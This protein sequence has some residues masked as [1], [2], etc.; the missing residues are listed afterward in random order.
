LNKKVYWI[1]GSLIALAFVLI[2]VKVIY[3][4]QTISPESSRYLWH[5]DVVMHLTGKGSRAKVRLTLP[6]DSERQR[7]YNEHFENDEL[8]FYVRER[9]LTG[10]RIG[11]WKSELLSGSKSVQY[12]FSAQLKSLTYPIPSELKIPEDPLKVYGPELKPWLDPSELIQSNDPLIQ[13]RLRKVI[14]KEK[15]EDIVIQRIY[16][17]VRGEVKYRSEKGSKTAKET[18]KQLVADCGGQARLFAAMSRAAGIP[19]RIVG[20]LILNEGVKSIT[21]NWVEDYIGGKWIPFDVV[22]GYYAR[23]PNN[24]LELYRG[25][26]ALIKHLG[27]SGFSYFFVINTERIPPVDNSW[28]LYVLPVHFQG[29]IKILLL[30]PLGA[31]LVAFFRTV[32]G[33]PTFGTFTPILLAIAFRDVSLTI[34]LS[35]LTLIVFLGW[36]LRTALDHLK[37]LMIPRLSVIVSIVIIMILTIMIVAFHLNQQ[38]I[39]YISLFPM[40]IMTWTIERFSV[41]QIEDGTPTAF[42][43]AL[44]T[45]FVAVVTY[46]VMR[47]HFLRAYLFA[48]PELLF[49][50]IAILLLLGRYT[51]IR[52]VEIWRFREFRDLQSRSR[53]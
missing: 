34:G 46:Y 52:L 12:T 22:N 13:K 9:P 45:A 36:I 10:N 43:A 42:K 23:L 6:H 18:L 38:K 39:L 15:Q 5:V 53:D 24:Y 33:V 47:L 3:G 19:S 26:Y 27:I 44:G 35:F 28:S 29:M 51:G 4:G 11:F 50:I 49:V 41:M 20:G 31:L 32:V 1:S 2:L 40:V 30:V 17:F 25:D 16:K 48:F 21:H 37:I 8:V 14:G 7:I